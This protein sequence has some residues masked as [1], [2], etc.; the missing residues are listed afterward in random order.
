MVQTTDCIYIV[1]IKICLFKALWLWFVCIKRRKNNFFFHSIEM[2]YLLTSH[3]WWPKK[4][5]MSKWV[6][7]LCNQSKS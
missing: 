1:N 6:P 3:Y 2:T 7:L 4:I 5:E